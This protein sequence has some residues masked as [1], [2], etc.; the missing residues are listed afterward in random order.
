MCT[1]PYPVGHLA[2]TGGA[3]GLRDDVGNLVDSVSYDTL[4][5]PNDFTEGMPAP[6]PPNVAPPGNSISRIPNGVDTNN[7][8]VDFKVSTMQTPFG[9]NL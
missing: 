9:P 7:N 8:K 1:T 2:S 5:A 6:N 4:T 3:V